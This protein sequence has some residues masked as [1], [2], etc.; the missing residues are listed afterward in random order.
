[1]ATITK[2]TKTFCPNDEC[3]GDCK[4]HETILEFQSCASVYS[5]KTQ[6]KEYY[7]NN[8]EMESLI[9]LLKEMQYRVDVVQF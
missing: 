3:G 7:F 4:G 5:F 8:N 2:T 9:E 1:M 6:E